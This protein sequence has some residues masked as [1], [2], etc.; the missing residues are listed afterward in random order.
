MRQKMHDLTVGKANSLF[1]PQICREIS[2]Q[3]WFSGEEIDEDEARIVDIIQTDGDQPHFIFI[4]SVQRGGD[5]R[6][7]Y[8]IPLVQRSSNDSTASR[9]RVGIDEGDSSFVFTD[10]V[11]DSEFHRSFMQFFMDQATLSTDN[12]EM[13][14]T[15]NEFLT[16]EFMKGI[17]NDTRVV[18]SEQ[19]NSSIIYSGKV[20]LKF[21]RKLSSLP[22]PDYDMPYFIN[23]RGRGISPPPLGTV[24]YRFE[25]VTYMAAI[26]SVY[27]DNTGEAWKH[28]VDAFRKDDVDFLAEG[29]KLGSLTAEMHNLLST[30]TEREDFMPERI[31]DTDIEAWKNEFRRLFSSVSEMMERVGDENNARKFAEL[32]PNFERANGAIDMLLSERVCKIRVHGDYHLGQVLKTD[33][34]YRIIDFEGEPARSPGYRRAKNCAVK[35]IGGMVRS[36]SYA[37]AASGN[38]GSRELLE[39]IRNRFL[40]AYWNS[41]EAGAEFLPPGRDDFDLLLD[42]FTLEKAIYELK[43]EVL[44]RPAWSW[45]PMLEIDGL[46]G[47]F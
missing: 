14:A 20:I 16:P 32:I 24:T 11:L 9:F 23:R 37:W 43:Y 1:L 29:E 41:H 15:G 40:D 27:V 7:I 45:I 2:G 46:G 35:D 31:R 22:S 38:T 26:P 44:Y 8:Q 6:E 5:E 4:L 17:C 39:D 33:G 19:S 34:G 3:R 36:F 30:G 13:K 21:F 42:F 47:K 28:F 10:A 25:G 18:T 12:G